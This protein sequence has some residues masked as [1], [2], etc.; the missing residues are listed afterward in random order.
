MN[1]IFAAKHKKIA[2]LHF[3]KKIKK[4]HSELCATKSIS[5]GF[6]IESGLGLGFVLRFGVRVTI[7]VKG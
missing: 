6:W 5:L 2:Q 3:G 4:F 1:G 7:R